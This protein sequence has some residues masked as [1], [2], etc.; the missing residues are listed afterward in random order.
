MR[1]EELTA[2]FG[3]GRVSAQR[4]AIAECAC[5][6]SSAFTIDELARAAA[7]TRPGI[8]VATVYRA[9]AALAATG[10]LE[11]VGSRAGSTLYIR[12]AY[13]SHHHHLVCTSCGAVAEAACPLAAGAL[14]GAE[15]AG[16]VVTSHEVTIYGLCPA[17]APRGSEVA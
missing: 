16:Y 17:C 4:R 9:V 8:G 2:A 13:D 3:G 6:M 15:Q 7:R 14:G 10:F 5:G 12:C 11:A 1:E